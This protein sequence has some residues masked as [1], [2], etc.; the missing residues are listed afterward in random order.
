MKPVSDSTH[1]NPYCRLASGFNQ[2]P[3]WQCA[4]DGLTLYYEEPELG[5]PAS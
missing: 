4:H 2:N 1:D 3:I 5:G